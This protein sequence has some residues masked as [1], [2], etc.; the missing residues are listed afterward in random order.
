M[1]DDDILKE[2]SI[3]QNHTWEEFVQA[4]TTKTRFNIKYI[5][6]EILSQY[7]S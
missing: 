3:L 5:N 6:M 7:F 2:N 4:I 1:V